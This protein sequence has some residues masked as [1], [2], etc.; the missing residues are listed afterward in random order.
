M[1]QVQHNQA[2][3]ANHNQTMIQDQLF[4]MLQ[5]EYKYN[6]PYTVNNSDGLGSVMQQHRKWRGQI[7][8]W[9]YSVVDH[10]ELDREV[11]SLAMDYFDRHIMITVLHTAESGSMCSKD[12]QLVAMTCLFVASKAHADRV[13]GSCEEARRQMVHL[14]SFVELSRGQFTAEDVIS[15]EKSLLSSL[16]WRVNPVTPMSFVSFMLSVFHNAIEVKSSHWDL[17]LNV[18]HESSRYLT[19]LA[20]CLPEMTELKTLSSTAAVSV[21]RKSFPPSYVAFASILISMKML[22]PEAIPYELRCSFASI[23][24]QLSESAS[25]YSSD[26][27]YLHPENEDILYLTQMLLQD[28]NPDMILDQAAQACPLGEQHPICVAQRFGLINMSVSDDKSMDQY[29]FRNN[30]RSPQ[31]ISFEMKK[32]NLSRSSSIVSVMHDLSNGGYKMSSTSPS[33]V[34]YYDMTQ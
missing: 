6:L 17:V 30:G 32:D 19:E 16:D 28:F 27:F 12:Y 31:D 24:S 20:V 21:V 26:G 29:I 23:M 8:E 10:F 34:H 18:L 11:V 22:T 15:A 3:S 14:N 9:C 2:S 1:R 5:R 33:H 7:C 13:L 25:P 4:A